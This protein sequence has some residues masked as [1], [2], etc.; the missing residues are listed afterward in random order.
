LRK[1]KLLASGGFPEEAPAL[2]ATAV[3]KAAAARMAERSELA[4]GMSS[5]SDTDVRRLVERGE[6]SAEVLAILDASQP[7]AGT[8][9]LEVLNAL[10]ATAEQAVAALGRDRDG[11]AEQTLRAA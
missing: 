6:F 8:P 9:E 3:Q 11:T 1:A 4:A 5:A 7:S 10:V 2:L